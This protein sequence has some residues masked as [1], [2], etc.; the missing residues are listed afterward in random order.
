MSEL[1]F[2]NLKNICEKKAEDHYG[3]PLPLFVMERLDRELCL[4]E[5]KDL[6][7]LFLILMNVFDRISGPDKENIWFGGDLGNSFVAYLLG[8]TG[9]INPLPSHLYCKGGHG[10]ISSWEIP[11][12]YCSDGFL[13]P[14]CEMP[15]FEDGYDLDERFFF[16]P[17]DISSQP[18]IQFYVPGRIRD[19][20]IAELDEM[21]Q[22]DHIVNYSKDGICLY[23]KKTDVDVHYKTIYLAG[24]IIAERISRLKEI[25]ERRKIRICDGFESI[26]NDKG[27]IE[28]LQNIIKSQDR[29]YRELF[30]STVGFGKEKY[31]KWIEK[32][33]NIRMPDSFKSFT[34]FEILIS[35]PELF[36]DVLL[37]DFEKGKCSY[38]ELILSRDALFS[39]LGRHDYSNDAAYQITKIIKSVKWGDSLKYDL[40]R[41][42]YS[43]NEINWMGL[44]SG[45]LS[46]TFFI[47]LMQ[48]KWMVAYYIKYYPEIYE[49]MISEEKM[50]T[51]M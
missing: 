21:H 13:C 12:I 4:I 37:E 9:S 45:N 6:T 17:E 18:L 8:L 32:L 36:D 14:I 7:D 50:K 33:I 47:E 46:E 48:K 20:I 38:E 30:F 10:A 41:H 43:E 39:S 51:S 28:F 29:K 2:E 44:L 16:E 42:G 3:Y 1:S 24:D 49:Q 22:I 27:I 40:L 23:V 35:Q 34:A 19:S 5:K 26:V 11:E 31:N 25:A 15:L